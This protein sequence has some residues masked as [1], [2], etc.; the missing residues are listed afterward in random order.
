MEINEIE[1]QKA[2][3][4]SDTQQAVDGVYQFAAE[5][6]VNQKKSPDEVIQ[7]LV[8]QGIDVQSAELV[9]SS[10]QTHIAEAKNEKANKDMLYGALWCIG[11]IVVTVGTMSAASGGGTYVVAW[12]AILFGA[13]QFLQGMANKSSRY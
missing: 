5:Q 12:G 4:E 8:A 13:I 9:V 7:A 10:L 2:A 1:T 3:S 6:L 11:G